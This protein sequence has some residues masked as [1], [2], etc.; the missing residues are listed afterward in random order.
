VVSPSR[1]ILGTLDAFLLTG[2]GSAPEVIAVFQPRRYPRFVLALLVSSAASSLVLAQEAPTAPLQK[3]PT[4][5]PEPLVAPDPNLSSPQII[6]PAGTRL[7]LLLHNGINT[8]TAKPGDSVYFE[9]AYPIAQN[10]RI[11]IPMGSFLRGHL[12]ETKRPGLIKGRGEFRMVLEQLTFPNGYTV[13][14]AATPTSVDRDGREGVDSEGKIKG[15]SGSGRDKMLVLATTAGG[16]YIGTLAGGVANGAPGKGALIGGGSGAALGLLAVLLTRG[17]EAELPR[18]TILDVVFDRPLAL[19]A[20]HLPAND[21][22]KMSQPF[23]TTVQPDSQRREHRPIRPFP[24][25]PIPFF[26]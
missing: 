19:E 17:P 23:T 21:P 14:L 10:N 16:A 24:R 20:D 7:P 22:G 9:T 15:A 18:G 4:A 2:P 26:R 1:T 8:R 12:L 3:T 6:V 25:L 13:S 5:S 11:V